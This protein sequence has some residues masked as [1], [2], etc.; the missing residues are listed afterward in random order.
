MLLCFFLMV[1]MILTCLGGL[2]FVIETILFHYGM[3]CVMVMRTNFVSHS[4]LSFV[5][6]VIALELGI[7]Y[8]GTLGVCMLI[9]NCRL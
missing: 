8:V 6:R 4:R 2:Q 1:V 7:S 5:T 9:T 3:L